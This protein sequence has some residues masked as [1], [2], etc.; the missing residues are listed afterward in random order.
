MAADSEVIRSFLVSLGFHV[1][2]TGSRKFNT[3]LDRTKITAFG[4]G[5]A[6]LAIG[7][8]AQTMVAAYA[9][10]MEKLYYSSRR[11]G[12]SVE[13]IQALE[14]GARKVG[15]AAGEAQGALENMGAAVRTNPGLR[16]L[17]DQILG[18]D[19]GKMDQ[20]QAMVALVQRLTTMPH[21]MGAQF[22][23]LFGIDER[24]FLM[25]KDGLPELIKGEQERRDMNRRAGIDAEEAARA[26][27]EYANSL[28]D[29]T[30]RITVLIQRLSIEL[31]P[32]FRE[33]NRLAIDAIDYVQALDFSKMNAGASTPAVKELGTALTLLAD[34]WER[35]G[36]SKQAQAYFADIQTRASGAAKSVVELL[37]GL[38]YLASGEWKQAGNK[39]RSAAVGA[40]K[41]SPIARTAVGAFDAF[42]RWRDSYRGPND[43]ASAYHG[44]T[45]QEAAARKAGKAPPPARPAP[46]QPPPESWG[47]KSRRLLGV[48][49]GIRNNNPGNI[50]F[51]R[52]EGA[53]SDG[54]FAK[55]QNPG[56]GLGALAAQLD[57]YNTRGINTISQIVSKW[58][59]ANEND[60]AAYMAAVSKKMGAAPNARLNLRDPNVL[61]RLMGS[62]IG[63]ENGY[64]PYDDIQL[65]SAAQA[66]VGDGT[67]V[68][69]HQKTDIHVAPGPT[70][71]ATA[72]EVG[73][74][75]GRVNGDIVRNMQGALR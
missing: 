18:T 53:T 74:A 29:L 19:T 65:L 41:V 13:N 6:I 31:L 58:A 60:T 52:Q 2:E 49:R 36:K 14:F 68:T 72:N 11:T 4:T 63:Q 71:A 54:R 42:N 30:G 20:A 23:N 34:T 67:G 45:P 35:I 22:A 64:N 12:A 17:M 47:D 15:L 46:P 8:A 9:S 3:T 44:E 75:Q 7:A 66:R 1:N 25:L 16:G 55:F 39:L 73:R 56:Q 26:S 32:A 37:T 51:H 61:S 59:P 5:K 38:A 40:L 27:V 33:F 10:S 43:P 62:I 21:Y 70:A 69:I 57:I 50:E 28:R 24:T 48:P